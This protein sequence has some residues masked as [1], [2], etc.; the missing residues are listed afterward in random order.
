MTGLCTLVVVAFVAFLS[1]PMAAEADILK[2]IP[3]KSLVAAM[4]RNA[5]Q[6]EKHFRDM[7][8]ELVGELPEDS[9]VEALLRQLKV[10]PKRPGG[11]SEA[12]DLKD[13]LALVLVT[14]A[15]DIPGMPVGVVLKVKNYEK[16][17]QELAGV[18]G[19][20]APGVTPDGT[21]V[22]IGEQSVFAARLGQYA[23]VADAE[24]VVKTFEAEAKKPLSASNVAALRKTYL[25]NDV[26]LY[27]NTDELM[28]TFGPQ[29]N[30]FKQM[31][32]R[33]MKNQPRG[34]GNPM[35]AEQMA[36][37]VGAEVDMLMSVLSQTDAGCTGITFSGDGLKLA[38]V[39]QAVPETAFARI[40]ARVRA[41]RLKLLESL[42]GP[43]LSA[44]GWH[45]PPESMAELTRYFED[46][47]VKSGMA[48]EEG[49]K[50]A[51]VESYRKLMEAASGEGA[52]VWAPPG[53]GK[54]LLRF[55]Y[56]LALKPNADIRGAVGE[57]VEKSMEFMNVFG[58]PVKAETKFQQ[59]VET[60][61]GC[62]IDRITVT[63]Q[64]NP[65][66]PEAMAPN[67]DILGMI[68]AIYGPSLVTY[69]TQAGDTLIYTTGY[70]GT[71]AVKTQVDKVLDGGRG[72]YVPSAAYKDAVKG[73]PQGR[74]GV[75]LFSVADTV[76]IFMTAFLG[77]RAPEG[78]N[79]LKGLEFDRASG[80]GMSFG[81]AQSGIAVHLHVPMQEMQNVKLLIERM[82]RMGRRPGGRRRGPPRAVRP[83]R[84]VAVREVEE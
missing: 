28:R 4:T 17:L 50:N 31:M 24:Y 30:A 76:K 43:A 72:N 7:A 74:S 26:A 35:R 42:D 46:F 45:I 44:A 70:P 39:Y 34:A 68:E 58:G 64:Q 59:A 62:T 38:S 54:G 15:F 2:V 82:L 84:P 71:D 18:V 56:I 63:F 73:L 79:P 61:R 60:H 49:E 16:L 41:V 51:F 23:V 69:M 5:E 21:D 27:V 65:E 75:M 36:K 78:E 33:Q 6:A 29:I 48:G 12:I 77:R 3:E 37:F 9:F 52:F 1:H 13:P 32:L 80:I 40:A 67:A 83:G 22:L 66:A 55:T 53:E 14:P 57:Y 25:T 8:K 11:A 19:A 81:P 47:F 20:A 10:L